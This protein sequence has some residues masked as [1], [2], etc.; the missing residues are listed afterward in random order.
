MPDIVLDTNAF[1][2]LLDPEIIETI[3]SRQDHIF[4]S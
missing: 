2:V 3:A 1:R 4:V